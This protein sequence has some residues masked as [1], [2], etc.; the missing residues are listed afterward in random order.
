MIIALLLL[1]SI[2]P[3][4]QAQDKTIPISHFSSLQLNDWQH[5]SFKGETQYQIILLDKQA[6]LQAKSRASASSLYKEIHIDSHE[7]PYLN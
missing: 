6:V 2:C 1:L 4:L 7:T 5:K 3:T